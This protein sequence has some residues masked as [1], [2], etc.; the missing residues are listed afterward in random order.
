[1]LYFVIELNKNWILVTLITSGFVPLKLVLRKYMG[2]AR[3]YS[4][5]LFGFLKDQE[6]NP[7]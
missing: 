6:G 2:M 3:S 7:Y 5:A 1:M 4:K